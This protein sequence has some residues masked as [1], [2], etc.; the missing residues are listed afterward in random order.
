MSFLES[1]TR[2]P[3]QLLPTSTT[4]DQL[5]PVVIMVD[6]DGTPGAIDRARTALNTSGITAT[7]GTAPTDLELQS[8]ARLV[9]ELAVLA[10]L[11][12]VI[13]V[14][15]AGVSLAVGTAS[16]VLDR[17]KVLGLMR[18]MGM[19]TS[20]LRRI[21]LG[22][23]AV[24]L[25]TVLALSIGL[26]FLVAWLVVT[27]IDDSYDVTWPG[28]DYFIAL[29]IS[30]ILALAAVTATFGLIQRNITPTTTRFA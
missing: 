3:V 28:I 24:P 26:G 19:P 9:Q 17:K 23:A 6:T 29:G 14:V 16:A 27:G 11:G 8:S 25:L 13:A 4:L 30:L 7:P 10:Y 12:M 20:A 21:I 15:V 5:V 1:W 22:E 18:L 2:A